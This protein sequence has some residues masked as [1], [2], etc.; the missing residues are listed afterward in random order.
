[1]M[2]QYL[3]LIRTWLTYYDIK[4]NQ[5]L[6]H[7]Q[8][9]LKKFLSEHK[10]HIQYKMINRLQNLL[11]TWNRTQE[12]VIL[13]MIMYQIQKCINYVLRNTCYDRR[14]NGMVY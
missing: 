8:C 11:L 2:I 6:Q 14:I 3:F 10:Q 9:M 12:W 13:L 4:F 1:M 7:S 5:A